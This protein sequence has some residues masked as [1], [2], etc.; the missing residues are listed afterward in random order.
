MGLSHFVNKFNQEGELGLGFFFWEARSID[1]GMV[2][3]FVM[4]RNCWM[5]WYVFSE[6]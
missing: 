1:M 5:I 4:K 3:D 2:M 6:M